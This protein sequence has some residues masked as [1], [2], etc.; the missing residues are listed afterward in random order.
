[1]GDSYQVQGTC[2]VVDV[3][4]ELDHHQAEQI[5]QETE[6]IRRSRPIRHLIF[7]FSDTS[8]MDSSGV[9]MLINRYRELS[10]LGG[11]V[12]AAAVHP[13]VKKLFMVSG[14]YK[15]IPFYPDVK[16]A[17]SELWEE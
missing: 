4:E 6:R 5:R 8:F 16:T 13:G 10:S 3:P 9:G 14:L 15:I 7:N 17:V 11:S 1:M 2:L 12:A